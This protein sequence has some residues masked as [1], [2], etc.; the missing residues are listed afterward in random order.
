MP[1]KRQTSVPFTRRELKAPL[2]NVPFEAKRFVV[3]TL[4]PV[5]SV[6]IAL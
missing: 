5:A 3:V 4:V 1:F 6:K 2:V